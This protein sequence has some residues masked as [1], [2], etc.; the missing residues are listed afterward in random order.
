MDTTYTLAGCYFEAL[1]KVLVLFQEHGVVD[2]DLRRGDAQ[3]NNAV[4]H[5]FCRLEGD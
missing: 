2:D 3:V 1:F 5:C 4:I